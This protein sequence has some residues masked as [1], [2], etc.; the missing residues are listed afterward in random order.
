MI[1]RIGLC[2][3][4]FLGK[5]FGNEC[6]A[7]L[8]ELAAQIRIANECDECVGEGGFI[9]RGNE[10]TGLAGDADFAGPIAIEGDD[11]FACRHGLGEGP[12]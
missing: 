1:K 4:G 9:A 10:K 8:A 2:N 11:R 12:G 6:A 5:T 7:L 3:H